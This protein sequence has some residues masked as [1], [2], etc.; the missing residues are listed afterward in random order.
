MSAAD[1]IWDS[2]GYNVVFQGE[3]VGDFE[4]LVEVIMG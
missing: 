4:V 1:L 3:S 2:T